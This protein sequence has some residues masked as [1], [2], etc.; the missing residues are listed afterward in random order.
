MVRSMRPGS[1]VVDLA[2]ET[3]GNCELTR[4]GETIEDGGVKVIGPLNLASSVPLHASQMFSKNV[5]T[6]LQHLIK[7]GALTVDP[8]DEITGAMLVTSPP[9]VTTA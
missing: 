1:V 2:A 4:A 3:G 9:A 6:I 8:A 7:D 5:V